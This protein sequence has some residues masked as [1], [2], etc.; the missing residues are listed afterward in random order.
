[1]RSYSSRSWLLASA[2]ASTASAAAS[3]ASVCTSDHA[4]SALPA[5]FG[6]VIDT[7]TVTAAPVY[8]RTT[9]SGTFFPA[10]TLNFCNVTFAY[11]HNGASDQVWVNYWLPEPANFANRFLAT[12]G[13]AYAIN[14]ENNLPGG[15]MYGAATGRTDGGFGGFSAN[16]DEVFLLGEGSINWPEVYMFG[17]QAI[18]EMTTIGKTLTT[19]FYG[20]TN[21][22][23][24]YT[25]YQGCSEGGREGWSQAQH[26]GADYDGIIAG[27]P[28]F[29]F[30]QQQVNHATSAVQEATLGYYPPTCEMDMIVNATIAA[31]DAMDGK[32]DG[33]LARPDLCAKDFDVASLVGTPYY[34]AAST[35][36]SLGLGF[37]KRQMGGSDTPAQ[38]GTITAEGVK[39]AQTIYD[40][41]YD[42]EGNFV[43]MSYQ[44]AAGFNDAQTSYD[45]T[46]G[47]WGPSD[48]NSGGGW[49][50]MMLEL[51]DSESMDVSTLT[52]DDLRDYMI[53]GMNRYMDSLQTN[54]PDLTD[55]QSHG[56]KVIHFH[57]DADSSIPTGSSVHYWNSV[58]KTMYPELQY[59]ESADALNEWYRLYLV[60][61]AAHCATNDLQPNAPFP[62]TNMAVIIDWVENDVVPTTLNATVLSGDLEGATGEICA[63]PLR[64][65]WTD[66]DTM[67][68]EYDQVAVDTYDYDFTAY[69]MPLY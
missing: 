62:Q 17:Y 20:T 64:P 22:T 11:T 27:A 24:L 5:V 54:N 48:N 57:G 31:C 68:C 42:S 59:N 36:S 25:Y 66:D 26:A 34:C 4:L 18:H 3:L 23:K 63:F 40:G 8:N 61:G 58:R 60:P 6:A 2:A 39:L 1:M 15:V 43:Y 35:S 32:A 69:K 45:S 47:T 67:V 37:G 52:Y 10:S 51:Y 7:T 49:I 33:I 46:T 30:G 56:G 12:G 28:A 16:F 13:G 14:N 19:N 44:V 50:K 53:Q 21:S 9:A 38:N 29:R 41:L 55:L 65:R